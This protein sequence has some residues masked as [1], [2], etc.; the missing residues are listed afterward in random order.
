[1]NLIIGIIIG[2]IIYLVITCNN[3]EKLENLSKYSNINESTECC[4]I[5]N[6]SY[7]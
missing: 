5:K 1:M 6:C 7:K 4:E 2:I 3:V